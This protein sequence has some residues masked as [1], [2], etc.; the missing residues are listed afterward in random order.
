MKA[1]FE[2]VDLLQHNQAECIPVLARAF[3]LKPS[4]VS[5]MLSKVHFLTVPESVQYFG[6]QTQPGKVADVFSLAA[7]LYKEN[8][9][10]S[11]T[12][13]PR[14]LLYPQLLDSLR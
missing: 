3:S 2:A 12:P 14:K 8:G 7:K 9:V 5:E 4:E 10:I 1:W 13:D 6:S 11:S